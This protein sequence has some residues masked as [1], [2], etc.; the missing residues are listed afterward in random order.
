MIHSPMLSSGKQITVWL[1]ST[2]NIEDFR[3]VAT[4]AL[5]SCPRGPFK[6]GPKVLVVQ[7]VL[8]P[9]SQS[10]SLEPACTGPFRSGSVR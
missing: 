7:I 4:D 2:A 9:N 8:L 1:M 3:A 5:Q 10:T 6:I